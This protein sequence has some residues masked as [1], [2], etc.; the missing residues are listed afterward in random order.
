MGMSRLLKKD[1]LIFF[2]VFGSLTLPFLFSN[3]D[4]SLQKPYYTSEQGWFLANESFWLFIY[5]YGI[6]LGY[7]LAFGA[8]LVVSLSYWNKALVV[9][10]KAAYFMLFVMIVG[11]GVLVN[12]TFK[13]H[14]G[15]PRPREI[16]QFDG[17]EQFHK[18]WVKGD[19]KGKS[20]PCGHASMGFFMAIPFLFLRRRYK[21]WAWSFLIFGT[22]YGLLIGY[23]RMIAGGHFASDVLWAAAMVWLTAIVGYHGFNIDKPLR[24]S[25]FDAA[26]QKKKGKFVALLMGL[27]LP[28][29]T[30]GL[31][32]ATP[33]ISKKHF[34]K[35]NTVLN[36]LSPKILRASF[37]EGAIHAS[38]DT[39]FQ[40]DYAV[41]G[42]GFPNSKIGLNWR[43]GDTCLF[44]LAKTGWFTEVRNQI[45]IIYPTNTVIINE[46]QVVEGKIF[47]DIIADNVPQNLKINLKEGD[48]HL[49][50]PI[51]TSINLFKEVPDFKN[52]S[53]VENYSDSKAAI[54][55][56][57]VIE[58]GM[59]F[60]E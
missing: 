42:F 6:F 31:L 9:W 24:W 38:F 7:F 5:K 8:L 19:T 30:L 13:E 43:A 50:L 29:F 4:I 25:D 33:Y 44:W 41:Q 48:V 32:L 23:A 52:T 46:L 1:L 36:Q 26:K 53:R 49:A 18:V 3:L 15:R 40:V 59:L 20:F 39:L 45:S 12:G 58:K 16:T 22:L 11:P 57:V 14:W 35:N 21:K 2:I 55:I 37:D 47:V 28:I 27:F 34:S 60:I 17:V 56:Q 10:R 51:G 54:Q